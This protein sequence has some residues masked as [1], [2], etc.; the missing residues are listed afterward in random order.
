MGTVP[1]ARSGSGRRRLTLRGPK[2]YNLP[3]ILP[4][5]KM[6]FKKILLFMLGVAGVV[7]AFLALKKRPK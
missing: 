6:R 5:E 3:W 1:L 2:G 7:A 4:E